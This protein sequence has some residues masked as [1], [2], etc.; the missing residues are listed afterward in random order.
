MSHPSE[1]NGIP[2]EN[3]LDTSSVFFGDDSDNSIGASIKRGKDGVVRVSR[4]DEQLAWM[5]DTVFADMP[6]Y[7]E[8]VNFD[9]L[10]PMDIP[11]A[12]YIPYLERRERQVI[13]RKTKKPMTISEMV[14]VS[15]EKGIKT[16]KSS[17]GTLHRFFWNAFKE[18]WE[19]SDIAEQQQSSETHPLFESEE[20][21]NESHEIVANQIYT[22]MAGLTH[23]QYVE[24]QNEDGVQNGGGASEDLWNAH[25]QDEGVFG[26]NNTAANYQLRQGEQK[27]ENYQ[28]Q[29]EIDRQAFL[30]DSQDLP[31]NGKLMEE[32]RPLGAVLNY[33]P[34]QSGSNDIIS[35]DNLR[36]VKRPALTTVVPFFDGSE[37]KPN[38]LPPQTNNVR[39]LRAQKQSKSSKKMVELNPEAS[40]YEQSGKTIQRIA[41]VD[42]TFKLH[43]QPIT[44]KE[45]MQATQK[46]YI[47]Q[48]KSMQVSL[49]V[50]ETLKDQRAT[51]ISLLPN[52]PR[53]AAPKEVGRLPTL[54]GYKLE[55]SPLRH[56]MSVMSNP[57]EA[58][59]HTYMKET[60]SHLPQVGD[61]YSADSTRG[62]SKVMMVHPENTL[63]MRSL[64]TKQEELVASGQ[65]QT[66]Y[67][68]YKNP[69]NSQLF[70]P[71]FQPS[72][73]QIS[74]NYPVT[75]SV[76][77]LTTRAA[78]SQVPT[79]VKPHASRF[80]AVD[81]MR[82]MYHMTHKLP[83]VNVTSIPAEI[84]NRVQQTDKSQ[85]QIEGEKYKGFESP[86]EADARIHEAERLRMNGVQ[87]YVIE[88]A[89][90][91]SMADT[92]AAPKVFMSKTQINPGEGQE[93]IKKRMEVTGPSRDPMNIQLKEKN[94]DQFVD[95]KPYLMSAVRDRQESPVHFMDNSTFD[96]MQ[97]RSPMEERFQSR[98][99]P[100][101]FPVNNSYF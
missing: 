57:T 26:K 89:K 59:A 65:I 5:E 94:I 46:G 33:L 48:Q 67:L 43:T 10:E 1:N 39:E 6:S 36:V 62:N 14:D 4:V 19:T 29:L 87:K 73:H 7:S 101:Q 51:P 31:I 28:M 12:E 88:E 32:D 30:P 70:N 95:Q 45:V 20:E 80:Q 3:F 41:R 58:R 72:P 35:Y 42:E 2:F 16:Y 61:R 90:T 8:D 77:R 54:N 49:N 44:P 83:P 96:V 91:E 23:P 99:S 82:P 21:A 18:E 9:H 85:K 100:K 24:N 53:L 34:G 66:G 27:A 81:Q 15:D 37:N 93:Y 64:P 68:D 11:H 63:T 55:S 74:T 60:I 13:D 52:Q 25:W 76:T 97:F 69:Q 78:L 79:Q 56:V 47:Q 86:G 84:K 92:Y 98:P 17:N 50:T 38:F 22:R 40:M 75:D 71:T